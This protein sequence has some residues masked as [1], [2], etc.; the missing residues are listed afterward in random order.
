MRVYFLSCIPAILKLNGMYIGL[1]DGFERHIEL[2][3]KDAVFAEI[4]PDENLQSL[5]FFLDEKFFASPPPFC[6]LYSMQGDYLL[7]IR[8][9]EAKGGKDSSV[10]RKGDG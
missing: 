2:D 7:Y 4:I 3:P 8:E 6:D 5:N 10:F 9:Y 1:V